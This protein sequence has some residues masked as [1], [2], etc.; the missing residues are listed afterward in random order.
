MPNESAPTPRTTILPADFDTMVLKIAK[1][2]P[3]IAVRS[4]SPRNKCYFYNVYLKEAI[5]QELNGYVVPAPEVWSFLEAF[6]AAD[7]N[8]TLKQKNA[9]GFYQA[10]ASYSIGDGDWN[11]RETHMLTAEAG[12]RERAIT[13]LFVYHTL[14]WD[15]N[16]GIWRFTDKLLKDKDDF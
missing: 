2:F 6:A 10:M 16:V 8:F 14:I 9:K 7:L 13:K 3:H 11:T 1:G 4:K 15:D 5:E 12:S